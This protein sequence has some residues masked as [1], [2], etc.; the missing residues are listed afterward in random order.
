MDLDVYGQFRIVTPNVA[1]EVW[2]LKYQSLPIIGLAARE[3]QKKKE[4]DESNII[5][6]YNRSQVYF[7]NINAAI[8]LPPELVKEVMT[9]MSTLIINYRKFYVSSI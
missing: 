4:F 8:E 1:L 5:T 3:D 9:G 6:L 2:D 7:E